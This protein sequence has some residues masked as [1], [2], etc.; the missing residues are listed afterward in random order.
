[1]T[2]DKR[3]NI[4]EV[5]TKTV[6]EASE[7]AMLKNNVNAEDSDKKAIPRNEMPH[8]THRDSAIS[9]AFVNVVEFTGERSKEIGTLIRG[10][11]SYV[12][13]PSAAYLIR[14][15]ALILVSFSLFDPFI[16]ARNAGFLGWVQDLVING[17]FAY[18]LFVVAEIVQVQRDTGT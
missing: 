14:I 11:Y 3:N 7:T 5:S 4:D 17:V 6:L 13:S 1:M 18:F 15:V 8:I 10:D 12:L 2:E 16:S 9:A